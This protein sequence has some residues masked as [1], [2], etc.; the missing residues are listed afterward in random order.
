MAYYK[1]IYLTLIRFGKQNLAGIIRLLAGKGISILRAE[2]KSYML[3][4]V[5]PIW[6]SFTEKTTFIRKK[7]KKTK[8]EKIPAYPSNP[9][10]AFL[11]W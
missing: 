1:S 8:K 7:K 4:L 9:Y 2:K 10:L 11:E 3:A 6:V 5:V